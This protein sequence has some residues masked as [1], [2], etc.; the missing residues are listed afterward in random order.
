MKEVI[1]M[2]KKISAADMCYI[3]PNR[4]MK[5]SWQINITMTKN[6]YGYEFREQIKLWL[7][8]LAFVPCTICNFFYVLWDGGLRDFSFPSRRPYKWVMYEADRAYCKAGFKKA[9]E[10]WEKA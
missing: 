5:G 1:P 2:T 6:K 10:I 7:F 3:N 4:S 8:I 9:D